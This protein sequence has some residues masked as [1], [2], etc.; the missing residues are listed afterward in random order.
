M[1][2]LTSILALAF[3]MAFSPLN[4]ADK[5]DRDIS[6]LI[7]SSAWQY[8]HP[9]KLGVTMRFYKDRSVKS[10]S[11][12]K[13]VWKQV[14]KQTVQIILSDKRTCALTFSDDFKS[15]SGMFFD[16][17]EITG[18]RQGDLPASLR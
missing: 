8:D 13:G 14:D 4:A 11:G 1:K 6:P 16:Q 10:S 15:Y 2:P 7:T 3:L 9:T 5:Q 18:K 17:M 12:W